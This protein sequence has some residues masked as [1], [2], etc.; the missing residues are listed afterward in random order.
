M[1]LAGAGLLIRSFYEI[2]HVDAGFNPERLL[3]MRLAPASFKY[4][5]RNDLQ[6]QLARNILHEV[7]GLAGVKTAAV[8]TDVPLLGN[9]I[10]IMRFEGR[11]P[12]TPSQA[13]VAN[14]FAVTPGFFDA[15]G[16]RIRRGR[17]FT[18]RDTAD[19]PLVAVVNQTLVDRY[20]PGQDPVGKRLEI[21]FSTP[22]NWREIVGVAADVRSAGLDQD[23]P[24]QVYT[25]Y[26]QKP[27]LLGN[28]APPAITVLARAAQD[29]ASLGAAVKSAILGV[30]R[31]Q[32]V[33][34]VQPMTEV[35]AK[36]IAQRRLSL[37]LLAFFALSALM[38]ASVG[39]YGVM[40][41]S[42]TERTGEIGIRMALGARQSQ[43]LLQVGT[44]GMVLVMAGLA[45]GLAAAMVFTR[46][47]NS[48]LFRVN[49]R[50]PVTFGVATGTLI[51]VSLFACYLPARRA[52][53]VDPIIAL[54]SE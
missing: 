42:V 16:M 34:A 49:A 5:G 13:P 46:F 10:Y 54:R 47:M 18:E 23:T 1:L 6:I 39:V 26:L 29:P 35:V 53:K 9:P 36:S 50:D 31:S 19:S 21:A 24:V 44:Q 41:Y 2:A 52:A 11:P 38:L 32:P 20:F 4:R 8:S 12:V 30:D 28:A 3:T 7:S 43:V 14:Y 45:A 27:A 40:S 48:L 25:A 33:Y 17:A 51:A 37:I 15:M 22:P